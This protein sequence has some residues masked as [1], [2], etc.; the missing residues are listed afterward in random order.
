LNKKRPRPNPPI[1]LRYKMFHHLSFRQSIVSTGFLLA[2]F[3]PAL[4]LSTEGQ[5]TAVRSP[6]ATATAAH[7]LHAVTI[8]VLK[9]LP[10]ILTVKVGDTIEWKNADI[11]SHTVTAVNKGFDSGVILS[12]GSWTLVAKKR[13]NF[14]YFCALHPNMKAKLVVQ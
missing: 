4:L 6:K 14:N 8:R 2:M 9:Y 12:G 11:V 13:G 3:L 1:K 5:K 7:T 10:P